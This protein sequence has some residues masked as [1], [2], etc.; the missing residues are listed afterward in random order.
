M[1]IKEEVFK[2]YTEARKRENFLKTGVGRGEI[3]KAV[4]GALEGWQSG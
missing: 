2:T 4:S 3:K 1:I